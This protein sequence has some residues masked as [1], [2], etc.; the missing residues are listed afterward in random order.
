MWQ[1]EQSSP[2]QDVWVSIPGTCDDVPFHG[3][4]EVEDVFQ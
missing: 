3:E 1:V 4:R 2:P